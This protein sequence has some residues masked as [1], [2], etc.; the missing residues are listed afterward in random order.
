[1]WIHPIYQIEC[2]IYKKIAI[3][4]W[5]EKLVKEAKQSG[6]NTNSCNAG[7]KE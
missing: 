3:F 4:R 2:K 5:W 1:M 7:K 6:E